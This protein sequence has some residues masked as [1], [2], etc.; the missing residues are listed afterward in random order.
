MTYPEKFIKSSHF[1]DVVDVFDG[2]KR[3]DYLTVSLVFLE[4]CALNGKRNTV[5]AKT[6]VNV[7]G[8]N[9]DIV[10][11]E[12]KLSDCSNEALKI[13]L[14]LKLEMHLEVIGAILE[15]SL[16]FGEERKANHHSQESDKRN[17]IESCADKQTDKSDCP[18]S[19]RSGK[20]LNLAL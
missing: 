14:V 19:C 12:T 5:N 4:L 20:S 17:G 15:M 11:S 18:K 13:F 2:A 16:H 10:D 1:L 3:I 9:L 7:S 8:V 6:G